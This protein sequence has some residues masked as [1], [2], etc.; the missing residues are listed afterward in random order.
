MISESVSRRAVSRAFGSGEENQR[1][2]DGSRPD[3]RSDSIAA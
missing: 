3:S 2:Y 1:A